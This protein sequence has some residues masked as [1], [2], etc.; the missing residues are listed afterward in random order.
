MTD[1]WVVATSMGFRPVPS[2]AAPRAGVVRGGISA[3]SHVGGTTDSNGV[4]RVER[5]PDGSVLETAIAPRL[6]A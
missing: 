2:A 3:G 1:R 5:L 6:L 4:H